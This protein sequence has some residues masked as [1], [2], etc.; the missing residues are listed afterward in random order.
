MIQNSPVQKVCVVGAGFMGS[1]IAL[2]CAVYERYVW[3]CDVSEPALRSC[4]KEQATLLDQQIQAGVVPAE[5]RQAILDRI[6][7]TTSLGEAASDAD[8][9]IEA[10]REDLNVKRGLFQALDKVCPPHTI[11]ATN[12]SS[13]RVSRIETATKRPDKLLNTHF[14]QPI[15]KHPFVELMRGTATSDETLETVR[16]FAQSIS[17]VPLLVRRE[18]TGFIFARIWRAVKKESLLLV[19]QGVAT[20]EDVDRTW[21][22]QMETSMGPFGLMDRIGLDVV[23]DIENIYFEESGDPS[24]APPKLLM[25]KIE[26]GDLGVKTGKGFYTYP[27]PEYEL[28]SFLQEASP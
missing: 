7:F 26:N 25:D 18:S 28:P 22:I 14:V 15:W 2:Q 27:S 4:G 3:V 6:R 23:R 13:L 21:M 24:D 19:D 11:L 5:R 17:V 8:L 10:I 9:V 1:Q 20:A 12:S 16:Q